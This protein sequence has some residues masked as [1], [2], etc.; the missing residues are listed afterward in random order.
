MRDERAS[1]NLGA[2]SKGNDPG[3]NLRS[4]EWIMAIV[5]GGE[6][7]KSR[8]PNWDF[9][10]PVGIFRFADGDGV[11]GAAMFVIAKWGPEAAKGITG[12]TGVLRKLIG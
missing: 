1:R 11:C 4:G 8:F 12:S 10:A 5:G 2:L 3:S 9:D 7:K 6:W